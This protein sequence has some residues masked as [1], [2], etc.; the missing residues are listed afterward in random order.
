[1][2]RVCGFVDVEQNDE[3]VLVSPR[4]AS[5]RVAP[6]P[7]STAHACGLAFDGRCVRRVGPAR[8]LRDLQRLGIGS[9]FS[10]CLGHIPFAS[11]PATT[12]KPRAAKRETQHAGAPF[13]LA[14]ANATHA[15]ESSPQPHPS[16]SAP[17]APVPAP[18]TLRQRGQKRARGEQQQREKTAQPPKETPILAE[19]T[20]DRNHAA[21]AARLPSLHFLVASPPRRHASPQAVRDSKTARQGARGRFPLERPKKQQSRAEQRTVCPDVG[22]EIAKH[23]Q[24]QRHQR[25]QR[26]QHRQQQRHCVKTQFACFAFVCWENG[27]V[28]PHKRQQLP[29]HIKIPS[30][31]RPLSPAASPLPN[32]ILPKKHNAAQRSTTLRWPNGLQD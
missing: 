6:A 24:Q 27:D 29:K 26:H 20:P 4:P 23:T 17:T 18:D 2:R 25:H 22:N 28:G 3:D 9:A 10:I 7:G 14:H 30:F 12:S 13:S 11:G 5:H 16:P 31:V 8:D 21:A 32:Q 19:S 15:R 1:M